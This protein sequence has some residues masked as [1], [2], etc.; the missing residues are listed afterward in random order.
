MFFFKTQKQFTHR[1]SA[2]VGFVL[3]V[4]SLLTT[5]TV[6]YIMPFF[7]MWLNLHGVY[8]LDLFLLAFAMVFFLAIQGLLLFGFPL[9]YAQ[10]KKS[11]M[12]G[13]Q[14][15]V[16]ALLWMVVLV[17]LLGAGSVLLQLSHMPASVAD[18]S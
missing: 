10:D 7:G 9:Y 18:F 13:L 15:L 14:I 8:A 4:M 17:G 2:L 11:H 6:V 5:G 1:E 16:Y 3:A 12:T